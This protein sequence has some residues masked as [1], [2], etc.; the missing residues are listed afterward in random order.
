MS[1]DGAPI[2]G[3]KELR[4][5]VFFYPENGG[6]PASGIVDGDGQYK[7]ATGSKTGVEPGEYLVAISATQIFRASAEDTP[8]G[9]RIIPM[10]YADPQLTGFRATVESGRNQFDFDVESEKTTRAKK[11]R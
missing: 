6:A 5:T 9:I 10:K 7:L 1:I 4:G 2:Q 8:T 11:R 3:S